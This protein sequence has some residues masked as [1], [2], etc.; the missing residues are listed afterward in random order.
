MRTYSLLEHNWLA[1]KTNN[2]YMK[3]NSHKIKWVVYD[4]GCGSRP[5]ET[6]TLKYVDQ[7]VGIDWSSSLHEL[8]ANIIADSSKRLKQMSNKIICRI[9]H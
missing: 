2:S 3:N 8:T 1:H 4:L 7:Y 9:V 5:Y 6:D